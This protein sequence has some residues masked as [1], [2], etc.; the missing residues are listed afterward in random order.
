M[1]TTDDTFPADAPHSRACGTLRHPHGVDCHKNC[2]TCHGQS[3]ESWKQYHRMD[4]NT[5]KTF[6][7]M[8][9]T[10]AALDVAAECLD[11]EQE[12]IRLAAAQTILRYSQFVTPNEGETHGQ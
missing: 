3:F 6:P 9:S 8:L 11:S 5:T 10:M 2:P 4:P 7:T 1:T 12:G